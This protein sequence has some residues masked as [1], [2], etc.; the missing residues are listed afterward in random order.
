[1]AMVQGESSER[2]LE[3]F[4][5]SKNTDITVEEVKERFL[6][7]LIREDAHILRVTKSLCPE[8]TYEGRFD[9]FRID[10]VIYE[11]DGVVKMVKECPVHGVFTETYFSDYRMYERAKR[12]SD[13]GVKV[14][15]PFIKKPEDK[16]VC[17]LACGLC[18]KHKSHTAL[19]NIVL[20]N[21]C[22]LSCWYCFFYAK[23]NEP[24]YEPSLE[25]IRAMLRALREE[26]PVP[27]NAVQF[28]GGE[29]ALRE[30][31]V[32]IVEMAKEEGFDHIQFNTDGIRLAKD[33]EL[34]IKLERA[35]VNVI[36]LSF[37]GVTPKTNPKNYWEIP[38]AIENC[39]RAKLGIVLVPTVI[40]G[41]NDHELGDIIRFAAANMDI[42]RGVNFQPVSMVGRM[43]LKLREKQRITIPDVCRKIEEQTNG[44]I[45]MDDFYPVPCV[46]KVT[47]FVEALK[48]G[49]KYRLSV[50]FA[51]EAATYVFKDGDRLVP[52]P[53]FVDVDGL[54]S[55]LEELTAKIKESSLKALGKTVS[56]A[57]LLWNIRKFIR[58]EEKPKDLSL[59]KAL[60][61]AIGGGSYD[62]LREFH[63]KSL[64]IGM[65]H[66]QDPYNYDVDR[67]ERCGIHYVT[68]D[69]RIIPFCAFNVIPE[70]YRDRIQR[71]YSIP[72]EEW[73]KRHP[74]KR[75]EDDKYKRSLTEEE[76]ARV[77]EFYRRSLG[78]E[79]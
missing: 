27:C 17:P 4:E 59:L 56:V 30:D 51:C 41:Y 2:I 5:I 75:L 36:Y 14:E 9:R 50:Q 70:L 21:R 67:V 16:V 13:E 8:C 72:Y 40:G 76:K 18:P 34:A 62:G 38:E 45:R 57:S 29:P 52:L 24:I 20:T 26:R 19:G 10:A 74:G 47:D 6:G 69:G 31:I 58:E 46:C 35:G 63:Y 48:G 73:L 61:S 71:K 60:V 66:F 42:I 28:T 55:Y 44:E 79:V 54:F 11:E 7:R 53:R 23:E 78:K 43:P 68:P 49:R 22:D 65:M 25:Q 15:N 37:D 64:F 32:E 1:M 12:Y 77:E 3:G 39:R 33:P